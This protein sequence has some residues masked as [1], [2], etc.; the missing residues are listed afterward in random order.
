[1]RTTLLVENDDKKVNEIMDMI[2]LQKFDV[3]DKILRLLNEEV[4]EERINIVKD[5]VKSYTLDEL[6]GI[7]KDDGKS[8]EEMRK[9]YLNVKYGV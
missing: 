5:N 8:Y 7:L 2:R 4:E 6:C 1:M 9:E 3:K